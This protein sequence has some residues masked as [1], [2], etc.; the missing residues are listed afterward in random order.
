[1]LVLRLATQD[2]IQL[3]SLIQRH[4]KYTGSEVAREI[5]STW[6]VAK[7]RFRKVTSPR[8]LRLKP[9]LICASPLPSEMCLR[10]LGDQGGA[11][12]SQLAGGLLCVCLVWGGGGAHP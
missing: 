7:H 2:E 8:S 4:L 6:Q 11:I 3:R 9:C 5:L 1:V 12:I 10:S